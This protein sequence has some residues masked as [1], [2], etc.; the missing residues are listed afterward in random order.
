MTR[1][2]LERGC[3]F[4]G[5]FGEIRGHRDI[6]L[7]RVGPL[8]R[9]TCRDKPNDGGQDCPEFHGDSNCVDDSRGDERAPAVTPGKTDFPSL[10]AGRDC[11][12]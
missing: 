2:G 1:L 6:G 4:L 7:T 10:H 8:L 12:I 11:A 3:D 9:A 5:G